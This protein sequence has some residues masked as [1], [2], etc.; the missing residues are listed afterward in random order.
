MR[1]TLLPWIALLTAPAF[2][3]VSYPIPPVPDGM[4]RVDGPDYVLV[5]DLTDAEA[6]EV[7]VRMSAMARE[8]ESR[9]RGFAGRIQGKMP[10]LLFRR[11]EEYLAAGGMEGS[12]GVFN[13]QVLMAVAGKKL[14]AGT[15][16][17][18]QHE[19]FHQYA[20]LV[21]GGELPP[22]VDEGLAEYFGEGVYCGDGFAT[23]GIPD[24]RLE[25]IRQAINDKRFATISD[26]LAMTHDAWNARLTEENYDQAWAMVQFLAHADD[27]KYRPAFIHFMQ[28]LVQGQRPQQAWTSA[29]GTTEGFEDRWQAWWLA[30]PKHP[31]LDVYATAAVRM[32]ANY[33]ARAESQKQPVPTIDG[34]KTAVARNA[35]PA[36]PGDALPPGLAADCTDLT[37][38]LTKAGVTVALEF[39]KKG[40]PTWP[41][42]V[43]ATL[44]D[45]RTVR[46][47]VQTR[48][49]R[50]GPVEISVQ[51]PP[52]PAGKAK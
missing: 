27:G 50:A 47:S 25:R 45:G 3:G 7:L 19:G 12:A 23:G 29:F 32:L 28:A 37:R 42:A 22:W 10:F 48:G 15:W 40:P 35:V 4:Q 43:T 44:P 20:H 9:T 31:T 46:G 24:Y 18:I 14:T 41:T 6:G 30:R 39:P 33:A 16:H 11:D 34:L 13:G 2:A 8:Y 52:K 17:V 49:T 36:G 5:H 1:R 26:M 38:S 21:I 51:S